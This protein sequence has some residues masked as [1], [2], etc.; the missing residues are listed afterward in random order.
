MAKKEEE[1]LLDML[2][3]ELK[4]EILSRLD[5]TS[6]I[7]ARRVCRWMNAGAGKYFSS[8]HVRPSPP[9]EEEEDATMEGLVVTESNNR[10]LPVPTVSFDV[11]SPA[12]AAAVIQCL[13]QGRRFPNLTTLMLF[14]T[15]HD[16]REQ[17][18]Q[19]QTPG[20][21]A[22]VAAAGGGP[23]PISLLAQVK[24]L[25]H[26]RLNGRCHI[27]LSTLGSLTQL[28]SLMLANVAVGP[29]ALAAIQR[30]T[31]LTRLS[32]LNCAGVSSIEG[33]CRSLSGLRSLDLSASTRMSDVIMGGIAP[34]TLL[35]S[36]LTHLKAMNIIRLGPGAGAQA[37]AQALSSLSSL[38]SLATDK[39][40]LVRAAP[41]EGITSLDA[42]N[43]RTPEDVSAI[44]SHLTALRNLTSLAIGCFAVAF[45]TTAL[46]ARS[47]TL[48]RLRL[49]RP[50]LR[51]DVG[52]LAQLTGLTDLDLNSCGTA[53]ED[54]A[55]LA[56]ALTRLKALNL[57]SNVSLTQA[58]LGELSALTD[59]AHLDLGYI[60]LTRPDSLAPLARLT[61]L[62]SLNIA[63]WRPSRPAGVVVSLAPLSRMAKLR[64]LCVS[65]IK[66]TWDPPPVS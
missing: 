24:S 5:M 46:S 54:L 51:P 50:F 19:Q 7:Q 1:L 16:S 21:E 11:M 14:G 53:D 8:V 36:C 56:G 60:N 32:L 6:L 43:C 3:P 35:P 57:Y 59:L 2:Q 40:E 62:E 17:Q 9:S 58:G 31:R 27:G 55:V 48:R 65:G 47:G 10:P 18:Q 42:G 61:G 20:G 4:D 13:V 34:L 45:D 15:E 49:L 12:H 26:L 37:R 63:N 22:G 23:P 33:L 66:T 38:R 25:R 52:A 39:A 28:D 41:A 44:L 64:H 29:N 30:L